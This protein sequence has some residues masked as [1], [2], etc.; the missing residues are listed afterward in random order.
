MKRYEVFL[1]TSDSIILKNIDDLEALYKD[2]EN[3]ENF[4][5]MWSDENQSYSELFIATKL[6]DRIRCG[7]MRLKTY[8]GTK[9]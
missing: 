4:I 1:V 8:G 6:M 2:V 9:E 5:L 3:N 7:E